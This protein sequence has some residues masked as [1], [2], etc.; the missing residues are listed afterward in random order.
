M[1]GK[2]SFEE[3][4]TYPVKL[5]EPYEYQCPC[6]SK[7]VYV[8]NQR[9]KTKPGHLCHVLICVDCGKYCVLGSLNR[10][11]DEDAKPEAAVAV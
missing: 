4:Q 9:S 5:T 2:I 6:G 3:L 7:T 8:S 1:N 10:C 11:I